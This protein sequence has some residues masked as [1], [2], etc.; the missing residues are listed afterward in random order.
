MSPDMLG[1][2]TP[3]VSR[4]QMFYAVAFSCLGW[5]FDMFDLFIFLYT[6]PILATVFFQSVGSMLS[7]A[8]VYA[9]FTATLI[10]RPLGGMLFGQYAD[11]NGRKR[12]MILATIGIGIATALTGAIPGAV[13]IGVAAPVIFISLRLVHGIFMGG[14]VASTHTIGTESIPKK[15]R[16]LASGVIAGGGS[17]IGKLSVSLL[18]VL[19]TWIFPG[20][21]FDDFGWR[22]LFFS[23]ILS[24]VLGVLVF[25][26][27]QESP[28][29]L[30]LQSKEKLS[31]K[32]RRRPLRE[33]V[34]EKYLGLLVLCVLLT[35]AGSGLTYL[36]SGYLATVL[37]LV[38]HVPPSALGI[39]LSVAAIFGGIASIISGW[40]TDIIGRKPAT[41][42]YGCISLIAIPALYLQFSQAH[43]L[44]YIGLL[45]LSLTAVMTLSYSPILIMLN[46]R[47]ATSV[48]SSGT[49]ISWNVGYALG[50]STTILVSL[51]SKTP[52]DLP[53]GLAI[54]TAILSLVYI[55]SILSLGKPRGEMK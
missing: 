17:A 29:W 43:N 54:A 19:L 49:A 48:R 41:L 25:T 39:I 8:G 6:A 21:A 52:Q 22:Y 55:G 42:L 35:M 38:N 11:K 40:L 34:D 16:G 53:K 4:R 23:G 37:R 2:E 50:G 44:Y 15:W 46:E 18:F 5:A 3:T 1:M 47:F 26:K 45:T 9:A 20:H 51:F 31:P 10:M 24:S 32:P 13:T 27:L 14:M 33:L 7:L 28:M 30:E 36:V 12:A